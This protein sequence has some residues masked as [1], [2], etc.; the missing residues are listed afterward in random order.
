MAKLG[1]K[2]DSQKKQSKVR[3]GKCHSELHGP[4]ALAVGDWLRRNGTDDDQTM[5]IF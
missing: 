3:D 1:A 4:P 2:E 5:K